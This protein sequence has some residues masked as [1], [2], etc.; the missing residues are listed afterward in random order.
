MTTTEPAPMV[1]CYAL[2]PFTVLAGKRARTSNGDALRYVDPGDKFECA[3]L[4][5]ESL[6]LMV[7]R[8]EVEYARS[9][10]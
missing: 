8:G 3:L 6:A 10:S 7:E 5:P 2:A 9:T 1:L 4:P